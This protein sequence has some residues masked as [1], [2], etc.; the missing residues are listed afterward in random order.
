[1]SLIDKIYTDYNNAL[2]S[3]DKVR[4]SI[5]RVIRSSLKN[6]EIEKGAPLSDD[7][8]ISV[9]KTLQKRAQESIDQFTSGGREDLAEKEKAE[10]AIISEYLPKQLSEDELRDLIKRTIEKVSAKGVGDIGKVMKAIMS[11]H[12]G[13][14]DGKLANRLVRE[15]LEAIQ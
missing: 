4:V 12:R 5:L 15:M 14:V 2:K 1:V 7:D 3:G 8:V 6:R 13:S 10:L 11:E 9:L